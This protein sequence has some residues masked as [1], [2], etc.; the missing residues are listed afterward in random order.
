MIL[1]ENSNFARKTKSRKI[2]KQ[3][4]EKSFETVLE[5][6]VSEMFPSLIILYTVLVFLILFIQLL[7]FGI[8]KLIGNKKY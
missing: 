1:I 2:W 5:K 7:I 3:I 8:K 6:K 4:A